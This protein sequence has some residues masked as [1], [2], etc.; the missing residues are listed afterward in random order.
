MTTTNELNPR[1][2]SIWPPVEADA[3]SVFTWMSSESIWKEEVVHHVDV[4]A[5][6]NR[7][8][9]N[10]PVSMIRPYILIEGNDP[11]GNVY[12]FNDLGEMLKSLKKAPE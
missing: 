2:Y 10:F 9:S 11:Y 6:A 4:A 12:V 8:A 3:N 5:I 7:M 1:R